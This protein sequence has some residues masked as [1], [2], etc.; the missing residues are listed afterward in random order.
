M[1]KRILAIAILS[2]ILA[3]TVFAVEVGKGPKQILVNGTHHARECLTAVLVLDQ[4]DYIAKLKEENKLAAGS[5]VSALLDKVTFVF[6]PLLNPDGANL[7]LNGEVSLKEAFKNKGYLKPTLF[8][9]W[10]ANINGVDLNRNYP[11]KHP[12]NPGSKVVGAENYKGI[13]L[14]S[15]PETQALTKLCEERL[16]DGSISYHSSGEIIFWHFN[17]KEVLRDYQIAQAVAKATGYSLVKK[18][19]PSRGNGFKD[20]FV[21]TYEKPGLTIEISPYVGPQKVPF[22]T[23]QSIWEKNKNVPIIFA[24]QVNASVTRKT[25]YIPSQPVKPEEPV[26]QVEPIGPIEPEQVEE[27]ENPIEEESVEQTQ[28]QKGES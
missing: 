17:Q 4:I 11:T 3:R 9:S 10:K 28:D 2:L 7:V 1:K 21:E 15:E 13:T 23:Y 19:N 22:Y 26:E 27:I 5:N 6:V 25:P 24:S 16:F 8:K 20:W 14:L 18:G 12:D